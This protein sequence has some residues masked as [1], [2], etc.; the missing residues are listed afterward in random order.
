MWMQHSHPN[1]IGL[2]VHVPII[3]TLDQ[4]IVMVILGIPNQ[5]NEGALPSFP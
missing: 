5:K 1:T 3:A 2:C 4:R